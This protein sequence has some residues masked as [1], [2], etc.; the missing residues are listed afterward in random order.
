MPRLI[1]APT[2]QPWLSPI[3]LLNA[4]VSRKIRKVEK[5]TPIETKGIRI[6]MQAIESISHQDAQNYFHHCIQ[7]A[8]TIIKGNGAM[9]PKE[10]YW[11]GK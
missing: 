9:P 2:Y 1:K 3:E 11:E 10:L 6:I 8:G 4:K 5:K 7:L